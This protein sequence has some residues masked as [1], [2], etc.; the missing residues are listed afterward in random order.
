MHF[1]IIGGGLSG[2]AAATTLM[3][4][5]HTFQVLEKDRQ[6][7]GRVKTSQIEGHLIDHGFQVYLPTYMEGRRF[8]DYPSLQLQGFDPGALVLYDK[9]YH[10]IIMDPIRRPFQSFNSLLS[11]VGSF[12]DKKRL[13]SLRKL[14][15]KYRNNPEAIDTSMSTYDFLVNFGFKQEMIHNFFIPFFSGVFFDKKLETSSAMFLFLYGKFG[16]SLA[17]VPTN[18][19][20]ELAKQMYAALP[21]ENI[22]LGEEV[23]SIAKKSVQVAS[24]KNYIGD[25]I[26]LTSP[27]PKFGKANTKEQVWCSAQTIYFEASKAPHPKRLIGIVAQKNVIVNNIAIMSNVNKAY[28]PENKHQIAVSIFGSNFDKSI[29]AQIKKECSAWF[30]KE[31]E[32]W[33][34]I[35]DI[36]IEKALPNQKSVRFHFSEEDCKLGGNL[37]SAGDSMLHGS[38]DG[39]LKSGRLTA[40]YAMRD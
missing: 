15:G 18:G 30:G 5:G 1:I 23:I 9:G 12:S 29:E 40:E 31:T 26:I 24:G 32:E 37:Y 38:I 20:G 21:Q 36:K 14:A 4:N 27:S 6:V 3:N 7:G 22:H 16:S 8:F 11:K 25:R 17:S 33:Q 34:L 19:M 2:L 13:I 28:A 39:A 35:K 10:D